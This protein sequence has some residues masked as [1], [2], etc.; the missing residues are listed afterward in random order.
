MHIIPR[1]ILYLDKYHT[2]VS[3]SGAV[4]CMFVTQ[5]VNAIA[6]D[7]QPLWGPGFAPKA[8]RVEF[9]VDTVALRQVFPK[10]VSFPI[11]IIPL[12]LHICLHLICGMDSGPVS[13]RISTETVISPHC[14]L[15]GHAQ[16]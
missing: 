10:F 4:S 2:S 3:P 5:L 7:F 16:L 1:D 15:K 9:L 8:V 13:S 6:Q 14:N 11:S 12:M